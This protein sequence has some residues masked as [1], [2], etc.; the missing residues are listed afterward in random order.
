MIV[1]TSEGQFRYVFH[2]F[3]VRVPGWLYGL[4]GTYV[5]YRFRCV[6][7]RCFRQYQSGGDGSVN[8]QVG[9]D[10]RIAHSG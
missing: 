1:T 5:P 10:I 3:G 9:G 8:L 2:L 4:A 6:D 7:W